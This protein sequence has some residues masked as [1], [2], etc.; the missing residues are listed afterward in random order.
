MVD[1]ISPLGTHVIIC[2]W[3]GVVK[4]ISGEAP[5]L[6]PGDHLWKSS[7]KD[8]LNTVK[9][10]FGKVVALQEKIVIEVS[11]IKG[12]FFRLWM[13]P[14]DSSEMAV[15]ILVMAIPKE[16]QL[17]SPKER[18]ALNLIAQGRTAKQV[19][20]TLDISLSSVHTHLRRA[21]EKLGLESTDALIGFAARYCQPGWEA[22][23][24]PSF[25]IETTPPKLRAL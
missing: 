3:H 21:R 24:A 16:I 23:D 9:S 20:D 6:K 5:I 19:A 14:L 25:E 15:C 11:N 1:K 17:L 8:S 2:D 13:W 12:K 7:S 22:E 10:A 4:W 18:E